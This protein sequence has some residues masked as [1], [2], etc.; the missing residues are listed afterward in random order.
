MSFAL[1]STSSPGT[2]FYNVDV[3]FFFMNQTNCNFH[4]QDEKMVHCT[5]PTFLSLEIL[6]SCALTTLICCSVM[7]VSF[8]IWDRIL[9]VPCFRSSNTIISCSKSF[10]SFKATSFSRLIWFSDLV[11]ESWSEQTSW[12]LAEASDI[13]LQNAHDIKI[14]CKFT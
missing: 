7:A 3:I 12:F 2:Q 11:T 4:T 9:M 10:L 6:S 5:F 14:Y 13:Y 8:P 1:K